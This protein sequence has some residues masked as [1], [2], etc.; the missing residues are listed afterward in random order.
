M[1]WHIILDVYKR[2]VMVGMV[3]RKIHVLST[4]RLII[5]T[6]IMGY[7]GKGVAILQTDGGLIIQKQ[8]DQLF[9]LCRRRSYQLRNQTSHLVV[10]LFNVSDILV[11]E[12][13][14]YKRQINGTTTSPS[15]L[16]SQTRNTSQSTNTMTNLIHCARVAFIIF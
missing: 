15:Q 2:Q 5:T 11:S 6:V 3:V 9:Q 14:V 7:N 1:S 10:F 4:G 12:L 16:F 13:D 8:T